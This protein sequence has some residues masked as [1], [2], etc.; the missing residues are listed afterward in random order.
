MNVTYYRTLTNFWNENYKPQENIEAQVTSNTEQVDLFML[1]HSKKARTCTGKDDLERYLAAPSVNPN[2]LK[3][4]ALGWWKV[5]LL[6]E[7]TRQHYYN[8]FMQFQ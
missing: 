1:L 2:S 5:W 6:K 4:G 8:L 7:L 3:N